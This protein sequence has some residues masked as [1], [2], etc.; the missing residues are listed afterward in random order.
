MYI[1]RTIKESLAL[2]GIRSPHTVNEFQRFN[3]RNTLIL[4]DFV[5]S[6]ISMGMFLIYENGTIGQ[7]SNAI[8]GSS[9]SALL[10][11]LMFTLI[12]KTEK[13]YELMTNFDEIIRKREFST[14]SYTWK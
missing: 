4:M 3:L 12:W 6:T 1:F 11:L 14:K 13:I 7:Y 9:S 5:L 8:Y 10:V 2:L